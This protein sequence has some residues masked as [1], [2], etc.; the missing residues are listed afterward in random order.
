MRAAL[1][2]P[3]RAAVRALV[4]GASGFIGTR[5]VQ[6][7][8]AH[9]ITVRGTYRQK[10]PALP[11]VAWYPVRQ[12]EAPEQ[13][14][15]LI[16]DTDVVVHLAAPSKTAGRNISALTSMAPWFWRAPADG[17]ACAGLCS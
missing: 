17:Q 1:R 16:T 7:I 15:D 12:L 9:G 6:G 10:A 3:R 4:T 14:Q 13:W 11:G 8:L 2:S 5:L